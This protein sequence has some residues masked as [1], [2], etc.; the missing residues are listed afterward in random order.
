MQSRQLLDQYRHLSQQPL[1]FV[2]LETTGF[3]PPTARVIEVSV[4]RATFQGGMIDQQTHLINPGIP[5]PYQITQITGINQRMVDK[6]KPAA[7]VWPMVYPLLNHGVFVAHN[8]SFDYPF[9]Q[10]E[11]GS[12]GYEFEREQRLCTVQLSRLLLPELP[13]RSLPNLVEHFGFK[14][15]TAH[16]AEADTMACWL[17]AQ[18]LFKRLHGESEAALADRFDNQWLPIREVAKLLNCAPGAAHKKLEAAGLES[19]LS[20]RS[21]IVMFQRSAIERYLADLLEDLGDRP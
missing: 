1:T 5:I 19:R 9:V 4:L 18:E 11:L 16:R 10:A 13:S 17:L 6:A 2:D 20:S 8:V 3:K 7:E 14:V 21:K 12:H 15:G